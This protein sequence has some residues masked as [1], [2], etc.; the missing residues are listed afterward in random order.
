M[1]KFKGT[2]GDWNINDNIRKG[3]GRIII[4]NRDKKQICELDLWEE[5]GENAKLIIAAPELLE[6]C[7]TAESSMQELADEGSDTAFI[8]LIMIQ[9]AI[10]KAL[11]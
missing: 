3:T 4:E 11:S 10:E 7:I 5:T 6:A 1:N 2:T 8:S 9:D